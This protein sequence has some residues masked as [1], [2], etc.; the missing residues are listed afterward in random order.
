MNPPKEKKRPKLVTT[1]IETFGFSPW[2]ATLVSLFLLVLGAS[3]VVWIV[4]SAPPRTLTI[5]TGP[6]DSSFQRNALLY[7]KALAAQNVT[8]KIMPSGGSLD[9]LNRLKKPN[10]GVDIGFVQGGVVEGGKPEDLISLGSV[11]Y[12]PLWV[13][14]RGATKLTR[15]AELAGKRV[16]VGAPGSGTRALALTL[17]TA[18]G[19]TC[20]PTVFSDADAGEAAA[21]LLGG[22]LD[23]VFLMGDSAPLQTLRT[24]IRDENVQLFSFLQADAYVRRYPYLNR[25]VLPRGSID[26]GK[27]LPAQDVILIGPTVEL[28]ARKDFNSALSDQVLEAAK[29]THSRSS[30]LQKRG[31]FPAPLDRDFNLSEDAQRY[32]KSGMGL[33][34]RMF[35]NFWLSSL[36]NRLLVAIVPIVLVLIPAMRLL[37]LV[38]KW[39]IQ[40]RFYKVYRPLLRLEA[41]SR[42]P[43]T[44]ER[45]LELL[46]RLD[47]IERSANELRVPASFG[48]QFYDLR[49]HLAFVR[50]RLKSAAAAAA[51]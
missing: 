18:N 30:L 12:Q 24:L 41:D 11:S 42:G 44:S 14:Y 16:A 33:F 8:L 35:H 49:G 22:K 46:G 40:L 34:Y 37:P 28:V 25:I 31:E 17:L 50:S 3:A 5:T 47:E 19:I 7:Q 6:E 48:F 1:L 23:A 38:Y 51:A 15:L 10:S 21:G 26:F 2:L 13:F 39:S 32:Y 27:D 29:E 43:L 9:N 45:A 20:A 36:L 4:L